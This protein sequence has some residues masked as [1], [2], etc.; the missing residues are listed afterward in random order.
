M[1]NGVDPIIIFNFRKN[2]L[3]LGIFG[4]TSKAI[5]VAGQEPASIPLP[6]IPIYLSEKLTGIYIDS[7]SKSMD[8]DTE[9]DTN[10]AG[11]GPKFWQKGIQ[12][13]VKIQM[14][15]SRDSIGVALLGALADQVFPKVTSKEYSITY[16]HGAVTVFNGLLHSFA[17]DQSSDNDLYKINLELQVP[18]AGGLVKA[19]IPEVPKQTGTVPLGGK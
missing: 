1:L 8:I 12:S 14:V 7:E 10:S 11:D 16:L 5:P 2:L 3:G 9:I 19:A 6:F 17:I 18:S 13:I 4:T 15:A